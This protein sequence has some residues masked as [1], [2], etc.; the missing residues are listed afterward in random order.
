MK[1]L[2][3]VGIILLLVCVSI[4]SSGRVMQ[5]S[6]IVSSDG[7]TL[8]VGGS[9]EGNYS[10]IQDAIDNASDGDTVFVFNGTYYGQCGQ[11]RIYKSITLIG[12]DRN[13]TTID[14]DGIRDVVYIS[15]DW[16]NL[17]GFTIRNSGSLWGYA[18]VAIHSK[19]NTITCNNIKENNGHGI[20]LYNSNN[21]NITC[22]NIISNNDDGIN[23]VSSSNNTIMGNNISCKEQWGINLDYSSNNSIL[24]NHIPNNFGGLYLFNSNNNII[25]KN[26]FIENKIH[27]IFWFARR[28]TWD[29]NYWDNWIGLK[30]NLS[31]FQK[32]PKV[33]LGFIKINFDWHPAS[34]PYDIGG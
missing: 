5:Q 3:V 24:D 16:V 19:N 26:N 6:S 15:A 34:E 10:K 11:V 30:I 14:G 17:S 2:L 9:G 20:E 29:S 1:K 27:A 33:I 13:N 21:N 32:F 28:N 7:I 23:L 31:I 25:E 4:P 18:G 12:Q 8:Y 22:N